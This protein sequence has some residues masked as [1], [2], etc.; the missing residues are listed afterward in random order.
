MGTLLQ[1]FDGK[2]HFLSLGAPAGVTCVAWRVQ[3]ATEQGE[4]YF[5]SKLPAS[6][7]V[8]TWCHVLDWKGY[9]VLP[10]SVVSPWH[11]FVALKANAPARPGVQLMQTGPLCPSW[12]MQL[13]RF[14]GGWA[15][16]S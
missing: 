4:A 16:Q 6:Q 11:V 3:M 7:E 14:F 9:G 5:S 13:C 8:C 12:S 15:S 2:E 1:S 10:S